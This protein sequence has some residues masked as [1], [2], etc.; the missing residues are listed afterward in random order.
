MTKLEEID[1]DLTLLHEYMQYRIDNWH[2]TP[3]GVLYLF[4]TMGIMFIGGGI[5]NFE[6]WKILI[7]RQNTR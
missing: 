7:Y 4:K 6:A 3:S 2:N 5:L 1:A